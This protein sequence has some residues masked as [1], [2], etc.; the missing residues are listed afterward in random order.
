MTPD[1]TPPDIK[2]DERNKIEKPL[3]SHLYRSGWGITAIMQD[4]LTGKKHIT[5]LL[6]DT[7][8]ASL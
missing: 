7:E 5:A 1:K 2:L 4:L 3:L 8:V 6:N